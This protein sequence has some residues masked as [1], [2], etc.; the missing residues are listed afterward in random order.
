MKMNKLMVPVIGIGLL[1]TSCSKDDE[2][3]EEPVVTET[4]N[5]EVE[6]FIHAGMEEIYLYKADV[7]EL[8]E[9]F[10]S[11]TS[12]KKEYLGSFESP[13]ALYD[14]LKSS[15][16]K[17]SFMT[18]DYIALEN[19]F[20]G[21]STTTGMNYSLGYI[22]TSDNLYGL[23]RYVLPGTSAEAEGVARGDVFTEVDGQKMTLDNYQDLLALG[24][25]T[26]DINYI[27]D[28]KIT[29]TG[30]TITLVNEEYVADPVFIKKVIEIEGVKVG[31]LMYNSFTADFDNALNDAVGELKGQGITE[32]ILDLRYN[33]GGSVRSAVDLA[34]MVTGQFPGKI[35]LKQTWNEKY[36]NAWEAENYIDRFHTELK[37]GETINSLNFNKVY[38]LTTKRS[39]SASELIINGLDAY[40]DVVQ[41]GETTTGKFQ[42]SVTLYDSYNFSRKFA[43]ENHTYAIQPLVYKSENAKGVTDYFDGL[44]PDV[45]VK[46]DYNNYGVLGDIEETLL[47]AALNDILGKP[48][49]QEE[50]AMAKMSQ[51]KFRTIG[52][53]GMDAPDYQ[54][55]YIQELPTEI[56]R[57]QE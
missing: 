11:S 3:T 24:S 30:N 1:F 18:A 32:L 4:K 46:E 36:Q 48:Q 42:A 50:A 15:Q 25:F 40:I 37:T 55:M 8:T 38:V 14:D 2:I 47:K 5:L 22:G 34:S 35:F 31:Y 39:A 44:A 51:E 23:V 41:V 20:K 54:R 56:T 26:I 10:F 43:N 45:E 16:D 57:G 6:E 29:P 21:V 17:F 28:K 12:R 7:P 27:A 9:G 19:R 33:G 53:T 52:E 49:D 13:E